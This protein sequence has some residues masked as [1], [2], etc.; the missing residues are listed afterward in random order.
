M[1]GGGAFRQ[2]QLQLLLPGCTRSCIGRAPASRVCSCTQPHPAT[3]TPAARPP[4]A[5]AVGPVTHTCLRCEPQLPLPFRL[6]PRCARRARVAAIGAG[7]GLWPEVAKGLPG[8]TSKSCAER[9]AHARARASGVPALPAHRA[10]STAAALARP[11]RSLSAP[12][13]VDVYRQQSKP[14][15]ALARS[16]AVHSRRSA[17]PPHAPSRRWPVR[18]HTH[19][20]RWQTH[21]N[22]AYVRSS[23]QEFSEWEIA[24]MIRVRV[25]AC[26][27]ACACCVAA[28]WHT[29]ACP[30]GAWAVRRCWL[31][32][33]ACSPT[34]CAPPPTHTR[35][36][37]RTV[38]R[39]AGLP[40]ARQQLAQGV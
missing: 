17:T 19:T 26:V 18:A 36:R 3:P 5:A 13:A 29:P 24:V 30:V 20:H 21:L 37:A 25:C 15:R 12:A 4:P 34:P 32:L 14:V 28:V 33:L 2:P 35:A 1:A 6:V 11:E 27:C 8:R 22:P 7:A 10:S 38:T 39:T 23:E 9:C 31:V 40:P 16:A